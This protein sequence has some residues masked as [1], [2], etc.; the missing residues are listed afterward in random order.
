MITLTILVSLC[1][2]LTRFYIDT[3]WCHSRS[4]NEYDIN[5]IFLSLISWTET[6]GKAF[7]KC[8][9]CFSGYICVQTIA[10]AE[11]SAVA[12]MIRLVEDAQLHRSHMEQLVE[13]CAKIY[14]P[15][16]Y[17][18]KQSCNQNFSVGTSLE[19]LWCSPFVSTVI[20]LYLC[21][22]IAYC[23][24]HCSDPSACPCK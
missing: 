23:N 14:T 5:Q 11:E 17:L 21:S 3:A 15:S 6:S 1:Y 22:C 13:K 24:T 16:K 7:E 8:L 12:R 20:S 2:V 10:L 19:V 9:Y 18:F 4:Y